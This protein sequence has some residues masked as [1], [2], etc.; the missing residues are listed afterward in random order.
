MKFK[1]GQKVKV[2]K[3]IGGELSDDGERQKVT[4]IFPEDETIFISGHQW[5]FNLEGIG[6]SAEEL[7][8]EFYCEISSV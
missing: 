5:A 6:Y 8:D 3:M 7:G 2:L 1:I 4:Q